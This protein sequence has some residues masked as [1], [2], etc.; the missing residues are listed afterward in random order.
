MAVRKPLVIIDG[1]LQ[2]LPTG[3]SISGASSDGEDVTTFLELT[4]TP[5]SYIPNKVPQVNSTGTGLVW[6][7]MP[8]E[9]ANELPSFTGKAEK[10]LAVNATEDGV[11]WTDLPDTNLVPPVTLQSIAANTTL[12]TSAFDGVTTYMSTAS[13]DIT[14][15]I[16]A[17]L[18]VTHA[19]T[20]I[21]GAAGAVIVSPASGVTLHSSDNKTK[22]RTQW[23]LAM[24]IPIGSDTYVL[25]G[26]LG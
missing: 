3:D 5:N 8:A 4:D 18:N 6:V 11:K 14:F 25:G 16:P 24:I 9:A 22:T 10:F 13:T 19:L 26:D 21:Q 1:L 20:I 2:E 15:T 23:S 7:D 12:N 17:G